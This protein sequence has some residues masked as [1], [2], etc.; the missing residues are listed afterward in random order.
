MDAGISIACAIASAGDAAMRAQPAARIARRPTPPDPGTPDRIA[1]TLVA[2]LRGIR[3]GNVRLADDRA[4]QDLGGGVR[5]RP[6][7]LTFQRSRH[8][9]KTPKIQS[10]KRTFTAMPYVWWRV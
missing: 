4:A 8:W 2:A 3:S 5:A 9:R 10:V 1:D 7:H 6:G